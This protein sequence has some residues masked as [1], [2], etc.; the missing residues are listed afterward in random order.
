MNIDDSDCKTWFYNQSKPDKVHNG[1]KTASRGEILEKGRELLSCI[2][3][4]IFILNS[5]LGSENIFRG[6]FSTHL[7]TVLSAS[8]LTHGQFSWAS[9][10]IFKESNTYIKG[11]N[12]SKSYS[13]QTMFE[14]N[15]GVV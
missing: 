4:V 10:E 7:I 2:T 11:S 15:R 14:R 6:R 13:K 12:I 5:S 8:H 3:M 1:G 9:R